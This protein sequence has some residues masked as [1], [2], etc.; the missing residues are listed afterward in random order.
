MSGVEHAPRT[1]GLRL[2]IYDRTCMTGNGVPGLTLSWRV[3]GWLY[4]RLGRLDSWSG[5]ATWE[6]ALNWLA[7]VGR[8]DPIAE[9]QY[10]GHGQWGEV[11]LD[12]QSLDATAVAPPNPHCEALGAIRDRLIPG[13]DALWWFRTCSTFGT[14][15]G[16]AFARAWSRFFGC[17]VAGHTFVIGPFQSGLHTLRPGAKPGWPVDEGVPAPVNGVPATRALWSAR[18]APNTISCLQGRIPA[19]F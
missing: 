2:M 5:A 17:R 16:H 15:R 18:S 14:V 4:G 1:Q 10:W 7:T 11:L 9:I 8:P 6:E 3:G 13:G 19:Q 12:H